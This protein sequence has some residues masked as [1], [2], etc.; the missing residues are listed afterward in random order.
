MENVRLNALKTT[1]ALMVT[2][3]TNAAGIKQDINKNILK[4]ISKGALRIP[5]VQ[6]TTSAMV[7]TP[8]VTSLPMTTASTVTSLQQIAQR[9]SCCK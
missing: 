2:I 9:V 4:C 8:S 5:D 7:M 6:T 3:A 1:T